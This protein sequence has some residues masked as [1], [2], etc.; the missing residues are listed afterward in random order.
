[1]RA[2][3]TVSFTSF[4]GALRYRRASVGAP[5]DPGSAADYKSPMAITLTE[6]TKKRLISSIRQYFCEHVE[7]EIGDLKAALFLDFCLKEIGP[8][9]YNQSIQ[10]AKAF[11][12]D[13][14][15]D[16]DGSCFEPEFGYWPDGR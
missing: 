13:R 4:A 6:E 9:I 3:N 14:V 1:M 2:K 15:A 11:M 7:E 12:R 10:D 5:L 8:T 16:L